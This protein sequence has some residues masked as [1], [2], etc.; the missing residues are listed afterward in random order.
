MKTSEH[1]TRKQ[2]E[3]KLLLY[4]EQLE[5]INSTNTADNE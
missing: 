1:K 2:T 3:E 5:Q 4:L